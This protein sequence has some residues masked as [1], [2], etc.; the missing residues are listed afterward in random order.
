VHLDLVVGPVADEQRVVAVPLRRLA[1]ALLSTALPLGVK[2][3]REH[4]RLTIGVLKPRAGPGQVPPGEVGHA[5]TRPGL[6]GGRSVAAVE[7]PLAEAADGDFLP[8]PLIGVPLR[9]EA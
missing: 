9:H 3:V 6:I 8:R 5:A 2:R 4:D 7:P 1:D